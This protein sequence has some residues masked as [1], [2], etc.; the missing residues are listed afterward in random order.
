MFSPEGEG[1]VLGFQERRE[2]SAWARRGGDHGPCRAPLD[3]SLLPRP[4]PEGAHPT[5]ETD[6][7]NNRKFLPR[8][9]PSPTQLLLM[10]GGPGGRAGPTAKAHWSRSTHLVSWPCH[11]LND[12]L[13]ASFHTGQ[14]PRS[15]RQRLT[16]A[17]PSWT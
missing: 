3:A 6:S 8:P 17:H 5:V 9:R 1:L 10:S 11:T 14:V 2:Q 15:Q 4:S 12:F 7:S 16:T 13:H